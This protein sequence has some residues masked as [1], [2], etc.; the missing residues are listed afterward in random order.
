[1]TVYNAF[2]EYLVDYGELKIRFEHL[3]W[4]WEKYVLEFAED[5]PYKLL[6][7]ALDREDYELTR[8]YT[9]RMKGDALNLGFCK[10]ASVCENML[11]VIKE[12]P[13]DKDGIREAFDKVDQVFVEMMTIYEKFKNENLS[14]DIE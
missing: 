14:E 3:L 2:K 4:V 1:M 10:L 8:S 12:N 11:D 6:V 7:E 13:E 9:H 5:N